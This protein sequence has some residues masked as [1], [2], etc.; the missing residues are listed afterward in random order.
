MQP[1]RIKQAQ[2]GNISPLR[3]MIHI[4]WNQTWSKA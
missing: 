2:R 1:A 4:C 3:K